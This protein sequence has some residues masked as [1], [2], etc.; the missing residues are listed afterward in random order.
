[1]TFEALLLSGSAAVAGL[2]F[3]KAAGIIA[4]RTG[5]SRERAERAVGTAG[6]SLIATPRDERHDHASPPTA[7][8]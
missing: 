8:A 2:A 1:M 5:H 3:R 4:Q 6:V 7:P